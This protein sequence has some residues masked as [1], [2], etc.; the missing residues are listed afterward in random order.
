M[1]GGGG[2]PTWPL[3]EHKNIH[4]DNKLDVYTSYKYLEANGY[5]HNLDLPFF[6]Q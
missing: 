5:G 3:N 4:F 2:E 6:S 1:I